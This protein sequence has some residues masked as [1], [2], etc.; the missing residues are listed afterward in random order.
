MAVRVIS[1]HMTAGF[2]S[3]AIGNRTDQDF[4]TNALKSSLNTIHHPQGGVSKRGGAFR[5]TSGKRYQRIMPWY[6]SELEK[7]IVAL[8]HENQILKADVLRGDNIFTATNSEDAEVTIEK[9]IARLATTEDLT[10]EATT[11][12]NGISATIR[13]TYTH[14]TRALELEIE[15]D[16]NETISGTQ[17]IQY[18]ISGE[19]GYLADFVSGRHPRNSTEFGWQAGESRFGTI[20]SSR[21]ILINNVVNTLESVILTNTG[22]PAGRREFWLWFVQPAPQAQF[23]VR[24]SG[25][26]RTALLNQHRIRD[27]DIFVFS[28]TQPQD[29][30]LR[31][32]MWPGRAFSI[33]VVG[34]SGI[35]TNTFDEVRQSTLLTDGLVL[36]ESVILPASTNQVIIMSREGV[37]FRCINYKHFA[38]TMILTCREFQP[39]RIMVDPSGEDAFDELGRALKF[40]LE[41]V[42]F[43][44]P[45]T[46]RHET[47]AD[48]DTEIAEIGSEYGVH[49]TGGQD[50]NVLRWDG[51]ELTSTGASA[52]KN[53]R[54]GVPDGYYTMRWNDTDG[55]P[56][57]VELKDSRMVFAGTKRDSATL[58]Y[59]AVNEYNNMIQ[60]TPQ[61]NDPDTTLDESNQPRVLADF[62]I[63]RTLNS[64]NQIVAMLADTDLIVLTNGGEWSITGNIDATNPASAQSRQYGRL[65]SQAISGVTAIDDQVFFASKGSAQAMAYDSS[66]RGYIPFNISA[67]R[68]ESILT[69]NNQAVR[70][71]SGQIAGYNGAYLV[72]FLREDGKIAIYHT[73]TKQDFSAWSLWEFGFPSTNITDLIVLDDIV[74]IT[75]EGNVFRLDS[76]TYTDD[77]YS[78]TMAVETLDLSAENLPSDGL[79]SVKQLISAHVIAEEARE[80]RVLVGDV[81]DTIPDILPGNTNAPSP[82][83]KRRISDIAESNLRGRLDTADELTLRIETDYPGRIRLNRLEIKAEFLTQNI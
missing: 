76:D 67:V 28:L 46:R 56:A 6:R 7:N 58:W 34:A 40:K 31:E 27:G 60:S 72:L 74:Y 18:N 20:S 26:G 50:G 21:S 10:G 22:A 11:T 42:D 66:F 57:A 69:R 83:G 61:V 51:D 4:R 77:G 9:E 55:W 62:G 52:N 82:W 54:L 48:Y 3:H 64:F 36:R 24:V 47:Q 32:I 68:N 29:E 41:Y 49:A 59:S 19:R 23:T 81:S 5:L 80:M 39:L 71:A 30:V 37:D 35:P 1:N 15:S 65:G 25:S 53:D 8:Y 12:I 78:Y 73:L 70:I 79:V 43:Y 45:P 63:T 17:P 2:V 38:D 44:N 33:E 16:D 14:D 75:Q 13:Y